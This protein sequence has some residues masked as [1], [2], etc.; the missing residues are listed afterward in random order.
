MRAKIQ[1]FSFSFASRSCSLS[2]TI[3]WKLEILIV[4]QIFLVEM[5]LGTYFRLIA[6]MLKKNKKSFSSFMSLSHTHQNRF[7]LRCK[8]CER[9]AQ[10]F[11]VHAEQLKVSAENLESV[12]TYI[13]RKWQQR[14]VNPGANKKDKVDLDSVCI[15]DS[16]QIWHER[17]FLPHL[18]HAGKNPL[19]IH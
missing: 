17:C 16:A 15:L 8:Q 14:Q 10:E 3:P 13:C 18:F 9:T 5:K 2:Q 11:T 12:S 19:R 7:V 1:M 6:I 4:V